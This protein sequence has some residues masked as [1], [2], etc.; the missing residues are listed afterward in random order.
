MPTPGYLRTRLCRLLATFAVL[1]AAAPSAALP[2]ESELRLDWVWS[3]GGDWV[4]AAGLELID[5][6]GD[7]QDEI[8]ASANSSQAGGYWYELRREGDGLVQTWSSL[9]R[10]DGLIDLAV[11]HDG[12]E[13]RVVAVGAS[14]IT[15]YD[16]RTKSQLALFPTLSANNQAAA[17]G[18]VDD[19][20][21]LDAVV[22]AD[23]DLY[24]YELLTGSARVKPGFGCRDLAIGQTDGDPQREIA[25][26][27]RSGG[28]FVL[29][30]STLEIDWADVRGFGEHLCLGDLDGDGHDELV[31]QGDTLS[32]LR[33]QDPESGALLWESGEGRV[34]A[35]LAAELDGQPG[36]ELL[37]SDQNGWDGLH[38]AAGMTGL[39]LHSIALAGWGPVAIAVGDTDGDGVREVAWGTGGESRLFVA[40]HTADAFELRTEDWSG[41]FHGVAAGDFSGTGS[42]EIAT[43]SEGSDWYYGGGVALVLAAD[44]GR[45]LRSAPQEAPTLFGRT[46]WDFAAAQLDTD[47]ALELCL[48]GGT[49]LACFDGATFAQQWR[50]Q[51]QNDVAALRFGELD[52]DASPELLVGSWGAFVHAFEGDSGWLKW[53]TPD[54][55]LSGLFFDRLRVADLAGDSQP[56]VL[57]G[58]TRSD[59]GRLATFSAATGALV[60]GPWELS[61]SALETLPANGPAPSVL[62]GHYDGTIATVDPFTGTGGS[63]ITT[64]PDAVLAFGFADFDRDG[65]LDIAVRL[66]DRFAIVD[67]ETG[68]TLYTSPYL[69]HSYDDAESFLVGDLDSD[70]ALEVLVAT[71]FGLA[72]FEAPLLTLFADGFESGDTTHW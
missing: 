30:G 69:G 27:A 59:A 56:E 22:C 42:R 32:G 50:L 3:V 38:V 48:A 14:T 63:A 55:G 36:E 24:V 68:L 39:E 66:E 45:L 16:A 23:T 1:L 52:G 64:L 18:D 19:D 4:G 6:D 13:L 44:T 49:T 71:E 35:L 65:T 43:A 20:G 17:V 61:L 67:G 57:A 41:P 62:L 37:W 2:V 34:S 58:T 26:A 7:G 8:L 11:V 29:D 72:M 31:A 54:L 40:P 12:A 33:A 9:P 70:P 46:V 28:G 51:L 5:L 60:A 53:R 47:A 21:T 10:E 25:V 15:V